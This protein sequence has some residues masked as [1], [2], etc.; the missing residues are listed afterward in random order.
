MCC[1]EISLRKKAENLERGKG[2]G[3][4]GGGRALLDDAVCR[5]LVL[6]LSTIAFYAMLF[7]SMNEEVHTVE[8]I[9]NLC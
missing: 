9:S 3:R 2:M 5:C 8:P 6:L 7:L 4:F 1:G